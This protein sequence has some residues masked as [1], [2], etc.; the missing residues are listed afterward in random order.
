MSLGLSFIFAFMP[1]PLAL[2]LISVVFVCRC[3]SLSVFEMVRLLSLSLQLMSY[4]CVWDSL[5]LSPLNLASP[6][7]CFLMLSSF[8]VV[9]AVAFALS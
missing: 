2:P 4:F 8:G 3:L 1:F 5:C 9:S 6:P 7:L